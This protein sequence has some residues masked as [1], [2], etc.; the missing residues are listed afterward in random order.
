MST[1]LIDLERQ[2]TRLSE[3]ERAQLAMFLLESLEPT[4]AGDTSG[5]WQIEAEARLAQVKRGEAQLIPGEE[6]LARLRRRQA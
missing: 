3:Q 6:V 2:A 1:E 5:A 4:E